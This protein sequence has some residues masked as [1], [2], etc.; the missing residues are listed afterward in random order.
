VRRAKVLRSKE[1]RAIAAVVVACRRDAGLKQAEL[2]RLLGWE[3]SIL[4]RVESGERVVAGAE[5]FW[6]A[7]ALK[8]EM[9]KLIKRIEA[10][11][12]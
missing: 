11:S 3:Q 7:R 1:H 12:E 6:I 2:A 10:F 4:A 5:L 8:L 9:A